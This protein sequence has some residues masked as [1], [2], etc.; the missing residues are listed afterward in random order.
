M[1]LFLKG[2]TQSVVETFYRF[3]RRCPELNSIGG[4]SVAISGDGTVIAVYQTTNTLRLF[5][6]AGGT[7]TQLGATIV[8]S[9]N[10]GEGVAINFDGTRFA[11]SS[12]LVTPVG[13]IKIYDLVNGEWILNATIAGDGQTSR[14][15]NAITFNKNAS[16]IGFYSGNGNYRIFDFDGINWTQVG[17][18]IYAPAAFSYV[19]SPSISFNELGNR[20]T[21]NNKVFDLQINTWVEIKEFPYVFAPVEYVTDYGNKISTLNLTLDW[22]G[23][24]LF[25]ALFYNYTTASRRPEYPYEYWEF[26][27][28][29]WVKINN[30]VFGGPAAA[31]MNS[32]GNISYAYY[33]S[34]SAFSFSKEGNRFIATLLDVKAGQVLTPG[35]GEKVTSKF[36]LYDKT[37]NTWTQNSFNLYSNNSTSVAADI[38]D[39]GKTIVYGK[40]LDYRRGTSSG[41]VG[42]VDVFRKELD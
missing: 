31:F 1:K 8:G 15:N 20:I 13:L 22:T 30:G 41:V 36:W 23:T 2:V 18:T 17:N 42:A 37:G 26:I 10:H 9:G 7:L 39:D 12:P 27:S 19:E 35:N 32:Q 6:I 11:V 38:S 5:E 4:T 40:A 33:S 29:E 25:A 28:G 14:S 16:R 24:K 21:A 3:R 34:G